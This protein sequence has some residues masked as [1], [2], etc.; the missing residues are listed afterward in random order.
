MII[1]NC[2][3]LV[4]LNQKYIYI[5]EALLLF[6]SVSLDFLVEI[7]FRNDSLKVLILIKDIFSNVD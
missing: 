3:F 1:K 7:V 5:F 4:I 2:Q 6:G